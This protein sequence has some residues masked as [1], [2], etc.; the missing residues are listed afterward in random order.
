MEH[1]RQIKRGAH[2]NFPRKLSR[3]AMARR[4]LILLCIVAAISVIIGI[5]IGYAVGRHVDSMKEKTGPA[6][7]GATIEAEKQEGGS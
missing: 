4:V 2:M 1:E 3:A 6:Y 5:I 7:I